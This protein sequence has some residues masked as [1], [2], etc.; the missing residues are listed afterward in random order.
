[1]VQ[2]RFR[3]AVVVRLPVRHVQSADRTE[4]DD[5]GGILLR[6]GCAQLRQEF[7]RKE[8]H[9]PQVDVEH[10]VPVGDGHLRK[11]ADGRCSGVV[12]EDVQPL[13]AP[14]ELARQLEGASFTREIR[15]QSNARAALR[16][17]AALSSMRGRPGRNVCFHPAADEAGG[18]H[19]ADAACRHPS[20]APS[21]LTAKTADRPRSSRFHL[22]G[23][24]RRQLDVDAVLLAGRSAASGSRWRQP[25]LRAAAAQGTQSGQ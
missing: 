8:E 14:G 19:G 3:C 10:Q 4:V 17:P 20:P 22:V 16:Q 12:D 15:A 11:A 25:R 21:C 7:A 23:F 5:P 6:C 1:M 18:D 9:R 2:G 13:L 24:G